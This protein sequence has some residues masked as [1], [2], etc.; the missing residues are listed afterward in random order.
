MEWFEI[1]KCL[2]YREMQ[3]LFL[4]GVKNI[5]GVFKL[6]AAI[7]PYQTYGVRSLRLWLFKRIAPESASRFLYS[8]C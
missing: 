6:K 1:S 2:S 3:N 7:T 5:A 8:I 4:N